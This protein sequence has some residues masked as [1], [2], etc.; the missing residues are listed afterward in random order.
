MTSVS[1]V[2]FSVIFPASSFFPIRRV[3]SRRRSARRLSPIKR[4]VARFQR[5]SQPSSCDEE[6]FNTCGYIGHGYPDCCLP[7]A[8]HDLDLEPRRRLDGM[9]VPTQ[10]DRYRRRRS[11]IPV[12]LCGNPLVLRNLCAGIHPIL[13]LQQLQREIHPFQV[14]PPPPEDLAAPRRRSSRKRHRTFRVIL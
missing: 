2:C 13:L 1:P 8:G 4:F 12:F 14:A 11:P 10:S 9:D 3:R 6:V 7:A 5:R